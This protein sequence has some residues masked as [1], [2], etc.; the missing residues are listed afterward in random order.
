MTADEGP[1]PPASTRETEALL[2]TLASLR[3]HVLGILDGLSDEALRRAVLPSGWTC[4]GLVQHLAIDVERFWFPAVVAG[5]SFD[6][7]EG[8]ESAWQV[9]ARVAAETVFALY[10]RE[11]ERSN[12]VI[13]AAS[14]DAPP[15]AWPEDLWP[16]WRLASVRDIVLH[17]IAETAVHCGHLDA[18]RELIDGR[19]WMV[20]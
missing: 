4:L 6:E 17:V 7:E 15:A 1:A 9:P 20:G 3:N 12:A 16:S 14:P 10:R 13:R 18:V 8:A 5:E 2:A 19:Q 11:I